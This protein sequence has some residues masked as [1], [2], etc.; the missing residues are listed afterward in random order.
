MPIIMNID[1]SGDLD[2]PQANSVLSYLRA[3]N[4]DL[5]VYS[6]DTAPLADGSTMIHGV[7]GLDEDG[8]PLALV[9]VQGA[10]GG[11]FWRLFYPEDYFVAEASSWAKWE[12]ITQSVQ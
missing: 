4:S 10:G 5:Q 1:D 11:Y 8:M 3:H 6:V 12:R 9:V 7:H 2:S